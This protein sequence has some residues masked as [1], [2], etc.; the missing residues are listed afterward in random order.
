MIMTRAFPELL[1][2]MP[3]ASLSGF[4]AALRESLAMHAPV[5][6]RRPVSSF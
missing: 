5:G 6:T 4:F 1:A 2:Q 3:V